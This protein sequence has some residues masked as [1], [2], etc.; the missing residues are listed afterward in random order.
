M[1]GQ[2]TQDEQQLLGSSQSEDRDQTA[3]LP[4]HDVMDGVT[5]SSLPLLPLLMDVGPVGGLLTDRQIDRQT[6]RQRDRETDR[7]RDRQRERQTGLQL[8]FVFK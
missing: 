4:V 8:D 2:L 5:E 3:T 1:P 6:D 7:Q